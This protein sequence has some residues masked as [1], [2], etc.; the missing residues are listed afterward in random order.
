MVQ[1]QDSISKCLHHHT[2]FNMFFNMIPDAHY[3]QILFYHV[4]TL[5]WVIGLWFDQYF[6]PFIYLPHFSSQRFKHNLNYHIFQ[7]HVSFNVCAHT[8]STLWLSTSYIAP[9]ATNA[10]EPMM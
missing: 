7:L 5:R 9:M 6:Q 2:L 1:F 4:L 10:Q 3:A 8:P